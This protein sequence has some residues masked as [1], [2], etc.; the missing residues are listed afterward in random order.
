MSVQPQ[1]WGQTNASWTPC[2]QRSTDAIVIRF[3]GEVCPPCPVRQACTTATIRGSQLTIRDQKAQQALDAARAEQSTQQ[4]QDKYKLRA[5]ADG[6][7]TSHLAQLE[8]A[9]TA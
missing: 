8:L 9:L 4:W 1:P 5:G 7:R 3:S 2:T 6:T